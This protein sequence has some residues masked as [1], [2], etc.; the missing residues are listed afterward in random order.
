MLSCVAIRV[1]FRAIRY[2]LQGAAPVAVRVRISVML[3][4]VRCHSGCGRAQGPPLH[5]HTKFRDVSSVMLPFG[6]RTGTGPAPARPLCFSVMFRTL[7]HHCFLALV[8]VHALLRGLARQACAGYGVPTIV[9]LGVCLDVAYACRV[10][11]DVAY[12]PLECVV[13]AIFKIKVT[14][15]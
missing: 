11:Y 1:A 4:C 15:L 12:C 9:A 8:D 7:F 13:V 5:A 14:C 6:L 10:I 2:E 3:R